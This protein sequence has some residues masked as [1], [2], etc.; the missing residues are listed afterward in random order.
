MKIIKPS[1]RKRKTP[2]ELLRGDRVY[3]AF[4]GLGIFEHY[5]ADRSEC[6]VAFDKGLGG[7]RVTS[8]LVKLAP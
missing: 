7:E 1:R 6:Y 5:A 3:H 2:L 8:N 4:R